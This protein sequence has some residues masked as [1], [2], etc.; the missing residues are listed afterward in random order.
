[1]NSPSAEAGELSGARCVDPLTN[2]DR[3]FAGV[4]AREFLVAQRRDFDLDI[5][6][7]EQWTRDLRVVTLDLQRRADAFLLRIGK[8][9]ARASP[10]CLSAT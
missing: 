8:E 5:D 10:R 6:A 4:L 7:V 1:M 9:A 2:D 3:S